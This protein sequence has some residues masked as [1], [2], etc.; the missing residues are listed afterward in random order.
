MMEAGANEGHVALPWPHPGSVLKPDVQVYLRR[1]RTPQSL[2]RHIS[3]APR[4]DRQ[5]IPK[6]RSESDPILPKQLYAPNR[7]QSSLGDLKDL[8]NGC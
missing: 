2:R 3:S 5:E 1:A 6:R 8:V 4:G 7:L